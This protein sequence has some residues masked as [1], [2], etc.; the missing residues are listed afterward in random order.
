MK[1]EKR[2]A[3]LAERAGLPLDGGPL[4]ET[5]MILDLAF[6]AGEISWKDLERELDDIH[7]HGK[8]DN[9]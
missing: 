5:L 1:L 8:D 4:R 9:W 3:K 7:R 2:I 6:T